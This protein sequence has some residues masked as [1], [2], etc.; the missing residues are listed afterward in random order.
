[1][2]GDS[3]AVMAIA[4]C[5]VAALVT[6]ATSRV[7]RF[8]SGDRIA[9]LGLSD[10]NGRVATDAPGA[11]ELL[12]L[13]QVRDTGG[14][15]TV[16][17]DDP[18]APITIAAP[19]NVGTRPWGAIVITRDRRDMPSDIETRL[20][21]FAELVAVAVSAAEGRAQL[22]AQAVTDPLTRLPNHRAF[23]EALRSEVARAVRHGRSLS[24][25]V[26]D[27]DHFKRL[28]DVYGHQEGDRVLREVADRL[29]SS[30][31]A[32]EMVARV[33]GEEF[34]WILPETEAG[35]AGEAIERARAAISSRPLVARERVTVSAGICD[36]THSSSADE[37]YRLADG[38]LYWAKANGRNLAC[39]YSPEVVDIL[40]AEERAERLERGQ[41]LIALRVLARAVDAK[42]A[43][44]HAHSER[45]A[46]MSHDVA[47]A[48]GWLPERAA[49]LRDAAMLHDVGKIGVPDAVLLK[50]GSLKPEEFEIIKRHAALGAEIT[51]DALS[52]EQCLWVRH[53]HEHWNGRGYPDGL[54]ADEIPEG[55]RL[56]SVADAWDVMTRA[57]H[58]TT[59]RSIAGARRE[60]GRCAGSQFWPPAVQALLSLPA[61]DGT[62]TR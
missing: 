46:Q 14:A 59:T 57:R 3:E 24:L 36:L 62:A 52:S 48:L 39:I 26:I 7:C 15:F 19:V 34:A 27:I 32:G 20:E 61:T 51:S 45:V 8:D 30:V 2:Q 53:H 10:V 18:A 4:A 40:S 17:P 1:V 16:E 43:S 42:D 6:A 37:L 49:K 55:S 33:G 47:L 29:A 22:A 23:H 35:G 12:S 44:T 25:A 50:T 13:G 58:Y 54:S 60:I 31:R 21:R 56:I 41:A 38:A 9:T 28:N 5:E 11:A